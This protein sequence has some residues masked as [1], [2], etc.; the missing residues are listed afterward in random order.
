MDRPMLIVLSGE[1][2]A[3]KDSV[4]KILQEGHSFVLFSL[5]AP[6]KRFA[7]DMFGFTKEQLYG[8]SS[9]RNAPD[10]RWARPCVKCAATGYYETE[11]CYTVIRTRCFECSG[12][13]VANDNSPRRV[14]QLLGSEYMRDMIHP[15]ALTIRARPDIEAIM[16]CGHPV[17]VNDAR[18]QNDRDNL[19]AW[20]GARRVHVTA[21]GKE[22]GHAEWR[23]H[24]SERDQP[25]LQQ[26]EHVLEN[27]EEWP[28]PGLAERVE[29]MLAALAA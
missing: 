1:A 2:G 7:E 14:L 20:L 10:P 28:F 6:L 9:A 12:T 29:R 17:V 25:D 5:S 27:P 11:V 22:K 19:H 24:R 21:P 4:A 8:P 18:Y 13:G 15:D 23:Q 26:V 3:G 16:A